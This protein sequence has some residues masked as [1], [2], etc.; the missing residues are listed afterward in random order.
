MDYNDEVI[1]DLY[2]LLNEN[3]A[4]TARNKLKHKGKNFWQL[5]S[6]IVDTQGTTAKSA[7]AR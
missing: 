1:A 3:K 4:A 2:Q 6:A 5:Q 7:E